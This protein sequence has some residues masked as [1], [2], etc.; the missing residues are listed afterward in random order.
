MSWVYGAVALRRLS[1]DPLGQAAL[2]EYEY[3]R[4][5]PGLS[6]IQEQQS[7]DAQGWVPGMKST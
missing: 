5:C 1:S 2:V 3:S 6:Y 7:H 4:N